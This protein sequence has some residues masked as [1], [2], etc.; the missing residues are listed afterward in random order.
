MFIDKSVSSSLNEIDYSE[1]QNL[2][3]LVLEDSV[4]M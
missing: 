3:L 1:N 4:S 2:Y